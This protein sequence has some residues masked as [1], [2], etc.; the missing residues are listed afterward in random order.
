MNITKHKLEIILF[1]EVLILPVLMKMYLVY[2]SFNSEY[3]SIFQILA[4]DSIIIF[5]ILLITYISYIL[6]NKFVSILL[7]VISLI[8]YLIYLVDFLV[9]KLFAT[10]LTLNDFVK[11]IDYIPTYLNQEFK[12]DFLTIIF[13]LSFI[14]IILLYLIR[15]YTVNSKKSHFFTIGSLLF[16]FISSTYANDGSYIHSWIY[17]NVIEYNIEIQSQS[18]DY[19]DDFINNFKYKEDLVSKEATVNKR[20]IIIL[21][22]ESL[23][24]YQSELFSGVKKWTPNIDKI[25]KDNIYFT[26]F[27]ANGF[28]TEDAEIAMLT[29]I[30]PIYAPNIFSNGGGV[31]FQGFYNIKNSLPYILKE[32]GYKTEF[33]TSSDL[34]FSNTREWTKSIGFDYIEGSEHKDYIGLP[35]YHFNAAEDKYLYKRVLS[36]IKENNKNNSFIFVKTV[37]SHVPFI[38]PKNNNRSEEETIKYVDNE[39]GNFYN[40]LKKNNFFNNGILIIVGDHHP[41]MPVKQE[42]IDRFGIYKAPAMVP[43]IISYGDRI[44]KHIKESFQ[45]TDIYHTINSFIVGKITTSNWIG[46]FNS[47]SNAINPSFIIHKRADR[48]GVISVFNDEKVYNVLLDGDNT[49]LLEGNIDKKTTREII[50]KIN[51]ERIIRKNKLEEYS[52]ILE[53]K[54]QYYPRSIQLE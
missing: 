19:S 33:I 41:T 12:F 47:A 3:V 40:E 45:Q 7:R 44:K 25:A 22:V 34:N 30:F 4:H 38:N 36:R 54:Q 32:K 52:K 1:I 8:V 43:M 39:V 49:S 50:D 53:E 6:K 11:F 29:G 48:R 51:N 37:S 20:N 24:S 18:K 5:F 16:L 13:I 15:S 21:M 23:S 35:R 2:F 14:I 9:L 42:A 31:S 46:N 10:H 17:K 27:Y 26:N 28:V